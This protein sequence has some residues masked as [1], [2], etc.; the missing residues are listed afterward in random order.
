MAAVPKNKRSRSKKNTKRN[1]FKL[2]LLSIVECPRCR[3]NKIAHRVC[4][5]CGYYDNKEIIEI[6]KKSKEKTKDKSRESSKT[7]QGNSSIQKNRRGFR[8]K[9]AK[10]ENPDNLQSNDSANSEV[11]TNDNAVNQ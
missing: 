6:E 10:I 7:K 5:A 2:T 9:K 4:Q 11:K 3:A 8:Q 1:S